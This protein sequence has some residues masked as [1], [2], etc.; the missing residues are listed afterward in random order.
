MTRRSKSTIL[1]A[2]VAEGVARAIAAT[3][4][5]TSRITNNMVQHIVERDKLAPGIKITP[6][7]WRT[8]W[9]QALKVMKMNRAATEAQNWSRRSGTTVSRTELV[10][11]DTDQMRRVAAQMMAGELPR[12]QRIEPQTKLD[13]MAVYLAQ[14]LPIVVQ[15]GNSLADFNY[16][17]YLALEGSTGVSKQKFWDHTDWL[18]ARDRVL[19]YLQGNQAIDQNFNPKAGV[20]GNYPDAAKRFYIVRDLEAVITL[21]NDPAPVAGAGKSVPT[22]PI[23]R[24]ETKSKQK[25]KAPAGVVIGYARVSTPSQNLADQI[26]QLRKAGAAQIFSEKFTG[27]TMARPE[28][29]KTLAVLKAGDTLVVTKIDRLARTVSEALDVL[30]GLSKRGIVVKIL[31]IGTFET[32]ATGR[33]TAVSNMMR[34]IMLAFSQFE[35]DMI[36]ERTQEGRAFARAHVKGYKEGRRPVVAGQRLAQMLDYYEDHTVA[37]TTRAFGVS[38]ATLMRRVAEA[39]AAGHFHPKQK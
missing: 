10:V 32:T 5:S 1:A 20:L 17:D 27:T 19:T 7:L 25:P 3:S 6:G 18:A 31:N 9:N 36:V 33:L 24:R 39:R 23:S 2:A 26:D 13:Q 28:L 16:F 35:R 38:K 4:S 30:D 29:E 12:P 34:T 14:N 8:A 11:V 22:T 37:E 15:S 21:A